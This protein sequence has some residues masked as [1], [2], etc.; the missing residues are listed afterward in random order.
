MSSM[1]GP[2]PVATPCRSAIPVLEVTRGARV[3]QLLR[4]P[5]A[6]VAGAP[7]VRRA[8]ADGEPTARCFTPLL[9]GVLPAAGISGSTAERGP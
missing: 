2:C 3:W 1:S 4:R 7:G 9:L 5:P 8:G 6:L